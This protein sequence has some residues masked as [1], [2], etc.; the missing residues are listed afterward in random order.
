MAR[1]HFLPPLG[2]QRG[3]VRAPCARRLGRACGW[4]FR[5]TAAVLATRAARD[6]QGAGRELDEGRTG[7]TRSGRR[8]LRM[9][10]VDRAWIGRFRRS[11]VHGEGSGRPDDSQPAVPTERTA[12]VRKLPFKAIQPQGKPAGPRPAKPPSVRPP[13]LRSSV[14]KTGVRP[15]NFLTARHSPLRGP[16]RLRAFVVRAVPDARP[17]ELHPGPKSR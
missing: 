5:G 11:R 10:R 4:S 2:R 15:T 12:P 6:A 7:G 17:A 16:P 1:L 3:R 9:L 8:G 13:A 14:V